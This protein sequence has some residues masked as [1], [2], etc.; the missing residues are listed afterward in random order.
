MPYTLKEIQD[1]F[2]KFD[3]N[4]KDGKLSKKELIA[5]LTRPGGRNSFT[6]MWAE[7]FI[8]RCD[9][10]G[11]GKLSIDELARA[12][13]ETSSM[14]RDGSTAAMVFMEG[15][16]FQAGDAVPAGTKFIGGF[17]IK[18]DQSTVIVKDE[19][20]D[21]TKADAMAK[22]TGWV[23]DNPETH[24][25]EMTYYFMAGWSGTLYEATGVTTHPIQSG[26]RP[27]KWPPGTVLTGYRGLGYRAVAVDK[28]G[29]KFGEDLWDRYVMLGGDGFFGRS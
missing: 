8:E 26:N 11:D 2:E 9:F 6:E 29:F 17:Y 12:M 27:P 18:E 3:T 15:M 13:E 7:E 14:G 10:D 28:V 1:A 20:T 21:M 23:K 25:G 4:P 22:L 16:K 24:I 19:F 5:I